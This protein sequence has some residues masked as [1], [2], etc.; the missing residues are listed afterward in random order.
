MIGAAI[1]VET[2]FNRVAKAVDKAAYRNMGHAAA[3]ISKDAKASL[4][5]AE[6][7]SLPGTPPHTHKGT[8]LRRAIRYAYDRNK[9]EAVIGPAYSI[10]GTAGQPHEFGEEFK[11]Q[12]FPE[13]SFMFPAL[14]RNIDRFASDWAGSA[15][16]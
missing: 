10:V 16:V 9:Q 4:E 7:P 1:K 14:E 6:G 11:G 8:Y 12:D 13:R 15:G 2:Q 5:K 3:S